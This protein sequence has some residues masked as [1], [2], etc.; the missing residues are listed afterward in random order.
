MAKTSRRSVPCLHTLS[1]ANCKFGADAA[2]PFHASGSAQ[3]VARKRQVFGNERRT[4]S[5]HAEGKG[6]VDSGWIHNYITEIPCKPSRWAFWGPGAGS[7]ETAR[8]PQFQGDSFDPL[9]GAFRKDPR[10]FDWGNPR[11]VESARRAFADCARLV[12]PVAYLFFNEP[13]WNVGTWYELPLFSESALAD[14]PRFTRDS[15][16]RFPGMRWAA[17]SPRTNNHAGPQDWVRWLDRVQACF[18]R[19]IQAQAEGF[20]RANAENPDFGGA[21]YFQNVD[22]VG[23]TYAVD[24][25]RIAA[26]PEITWLC[27]E[28]V[29]DAN[30]PAWKRFK[31]TAQKHHKQLS[32]FVNIGHYDSASPGRVRYQGTDSAFESAVRMGPEEHAPMVTLYPAGSLNRA[33]PGYNKART[34]IWDRLTAPSK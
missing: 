34:E 31:Y 30:A 6:R 2:N 21:I 27:A 17:D 24:L 32:S 9:T 22:W 28:Y 5:K 29:T 7:A 14:F 8:Q 26:L 33:S 18:A 15:Q 23:P 25:D 3:E 1:A 13:H 16:A 20:A 11:A 10:F 4:V 19:S 12:G